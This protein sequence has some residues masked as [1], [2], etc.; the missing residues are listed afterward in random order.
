[1]FNRF[2][3]ILTT[4]KSIKQQKWKIKYNNLSNVGDNGINGGNCLSKESK[5]NID[6]LKSIIL[7]LSESNKAIKK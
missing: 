6:A 7:N 1:M 4:S 3:W 5:G 2:S